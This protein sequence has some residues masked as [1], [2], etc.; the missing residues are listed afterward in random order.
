MRMYGEA[1]MEFAELFNVDPEEAIDNVDRAFEAKLERFHSL[2]DASKSIF[3]Y[4]ESGETSLL[5]A[6]RN[7]VHHRDHPLFHSLNR[8]LHL[9]DEGKRWLGASF[10]IGRHPTTHGEQIPMSHLVRLDD[11]DARLDPDFG[12]T[13]VDRLVKGDKARQRFKVINDH[14]NL[15]SIRAQALKNR[16][17]RDQVY[18]DLMP[19]YVAATCKVFK[20]LKKAGIEFIG[21]DAKTYFTPFTTELAVDLSHVDFSRLR[22]RGLGPLDLVPVPARL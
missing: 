3:P 9:Q 14:L 1:Q 10:L 19:V 18:L 5:I 22:L 12:S 6:I 16:Y 7:A 21:F 20:A 17:P 13:H 15:G 8:R 11:I 2:Y 4:F